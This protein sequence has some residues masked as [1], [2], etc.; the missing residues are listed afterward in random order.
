MAF[1]A[2]SLEQRIYL[3][4]K[5]AVSGGV[6]VYHIMPPENASAPYVVFQR[7]STVFDHTLQ[8]QSQLITALIQIDCWNDTDIRAANEAGKIRRALAGLRES[9][10]VNRISAAICDSELSTV[11]PESKLYRRSLTFRVMMREDPAD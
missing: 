3:A 2:T 1:A 6:E 8:A 10:I 4:I 11:D 7:I 5:V 9:N